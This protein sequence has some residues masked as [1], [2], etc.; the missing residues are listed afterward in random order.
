VQGTEEQDL[1]LEGDSGELQKGRGRGGMNNNCAWARGSLRG[2]S[3]CAKKPGFIENTRGKHNTQHTTYN[4]VVLQCLPKTN[5]KPMVTA[6][7]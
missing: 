3:K 2:R 7:K 4:A 1:G 5:F 6:S